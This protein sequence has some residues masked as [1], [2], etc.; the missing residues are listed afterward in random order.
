MNPRERIEELLADRALW[1]LSET[2]QRE[3][4]T[5]ESENELQLEFEETA[6]LASVGLTA[7]D[8]EGVP[9]GLVAKLEAEALGFVASRRGLAADRVLEAMDRADDG[10]SSAPTVPNAP[11]PIAWGWLV[12][13]A[14]LLLGLLWVGFLRDGRESSERARGQIVAMADTQK[15]DWKAGP[16]PFAGTV[17]GDVVWSQRLQ[18]GFMRFQ[19]LPVND[20]TERQYQLWIFDS[21]RDEKRPVDGGVFDIDRETGEAIVPIR[22]A[23][24]VG[25][26]VAFAVTVEKPGGVVVS[27][28]DH[29]VATAGL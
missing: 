3:L 4:D 13:A 1:G 8:R 22:A 24:K 11:A 14:A 5:L 17:R 25:E 23:L 28:R 9:P 15:I 29:I 6:A 26:A 27:G 18:K 19:G 2:E 12:A 16:S 7:V 20:P 21:T 10:S